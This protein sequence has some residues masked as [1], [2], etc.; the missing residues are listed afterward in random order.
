[1][2]NVLLYKQNFSILNSYT[3]KEVPFLYKGD[4]NPNYIRVSEE[5][6]PLSAENKSLTVSELDALP[7]FNRVPVSGGKDDWEH[8]LTRSDFTGNHLQASGMALSEILSSRKDDFPSDVDWSN[9]SMTK[10]GDDMTVSGYNDGE[11]VSGTSRDILYPWKNEWSQISV[12]KDA[13]SLDLSVDLNSSVIRVL[14]GV[15]TIEPTERRWTSGKTVIPNYNYPYSTGA[16]DLEVSGNQS[17]N[18]IYKILNSESKGYERKWLLQSSRTAI[19]WNDQKKYWQLISYES[20]NKEK[21]E[22]IASGYPH[23]TQYISPFDTQWIYGTVHE[24]SKRIE[25]LNGGTNVCTAHGTDPFSNWSMGT[26]ED[27]D[28][29]GG[30]IKIYGTFF[31]ELSQNKTNHLGNWTN[32]VNVVAKGDNLDVS[33]FDNEDVN[34][35]Y[36]LF[37][38]S[39]SSRIWLKKGR[40]SK[41]SIS[42]NSIGLY[43]QLCTTVDGLYEMSDRSASG[44]FRVWKDAIAIDNVTYFTNIICFSR[45]ENAWHIKNCKRLDLTFK[46]SQQSEEGSDILWTSGEYH[47]E[48]SPEDYCWKLYDVAGNI[49]SCQNITPDSWDDFDQ[50]TDY[51]NTVVD[52][53]NYKVIMNNAQFSGDYSLESFDSSIHPFSMSKDASI[54]TYYVTYDIRASRWK[55]VIRLNIDG[56]YK[57][58]QASAP[59]KLRKWEKLSSSLMVENSYKIVYNQ[60]NSRWEIIDY[61]TED[62]SYDHAG[63][64]RMFSMPF[65]GDWEN[66]KVIEGDGDSIEISDFSGWEDASGTYSQH[67]QQE[68]IYSLTKDEVFQ[69]SKNYFIKVG[70]SYEIAIVVPGDQIEP[71]SYYEAPEE[72]QKI[73]RRTGSNG[74]YRILW[75]ND[76]K[77]WVL[78]FVNTKVNTTYEYSRGSTRNLDKWTKSIGPL[79]YTISWDQQNKQ[80]V[81][82]NGQNVISHSSSTTLE[83]IDSGWP[84]QVNISKSDQNLLVSGLE[85]REANGTYLPD[86]QQ[87]AISDFER[88]W[89]KTSTDGTSLFKIRFNLNNLK[90]EINHDDLDINGSYDPYPEGNNDVGHNRRWS[91]KGLKYDQ[92]GNLI[93]YLI[94][95]N[96]SSS[97]WEIRRLNE[98]FSTLDQSA[99]SSKEY[100]VYVSEAQAYAKIE[101]GVNYSS[102]DEYAT[103]NVTVGG[104]TYDIGTVYIR[105]SSVSGHE[106][107]RWFERHSVLAYQTTP[108]DEPTGGVWSSG[109]ITDP[110]ASSSVWS[111][112]IK[113]TQPENQQYNLTVSGNNNSEGTKIRYN[114]SYLIQDRTAKGSNRLWKSANNLYVKWVESNNAW[115]ITSNRSLD[116]LNDAYS[117]Y[118]DVVCAWTNSSSSYANVQDLSTLSWNTN[119][120][121]FSGNFKIASEPE[122]ET[123]SNRQFWAIA[124]YSYQDG[125]TLRY[126]TSNRVSL[127]LSIVNDDIS[128]VSLNLI[129]SSGDQNYTGFYISKESDSIVRNNYIPTDLI[130]VNYSAYSLNNIRIKFSGVTVPGVDWDHDHTVPSIISRTGILDQTRLGDDDTVFEITM[131]VKDEAGNSRTLSKKIT[132]ISRLWR[133]KGTNIKED[134]S[135]YSTNVYSISP[136]GGLT[137][138]PKTK[139]DDSEYGYVRAWDDIFYPA[140]HGYPKL[141]D[142]KIDEINAIRISQETIDESGKTGPTSA[143]LKIYDRLNLSTDKTSLSTDQDGRY[144]TSGWN[145]SKKYNRMESSSYG[146]SGENLKYWIIDNSGYS[147]LQLEFEYFDLSSQVSNIPR[148]NLSPYEGDV[149][150]IYDASAE[151]CLGS[152]TDI[153]GK[154]H[155]VLADSSKLVEIYAFTGSHYNDDIAM[156]SDGSYTFDLQDFGFI[157]PKITST[158]KICLILYTDNDHE[159]SGF[160]I[161]SGPKHAATLY[162]YELKNDTGEIWIHISPESKDG[163]Y[164][165]PSRV[166]TTHQYTTANALI[167]HERSRVIF[168]SNE[169][170]TITGDLTAYS[171][172]KSIHDIGRTSLDPSGEWI[173]SNETPKSNFRHLTTGITD[174]AYSDIKTFLLYNDDCVDYYDISLCVAPSGKSTNYSDIYDYL[175]PSRNFGKIV[176]G[177]TTNKDKGVISFTSSVPLGR[178]FASYNYHTYYRL[179]NDGYGDLYFY[180]NALIPSSDYS[181]TGLKDWTYV[182]LMIYNEGSN[183]LSEGLMKFMSRGYISGSGSTQT[184]TQVVDENRPW[185][186]QSGTV[187]ETVNQTGASF[188]SSYA[189][190]PAKTRSA[191]MNAISRSS[192]GVSLGSVLGARSKAYMRIYWCLAQSE[193]GSSVTYITTTRG[194]KLWSSEISGKY[195]VVTM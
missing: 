175:N 29:D 116:S 33:G 6:I 94:N 49:I 100:Y 57:L 125:S 45:Y 147:D 123:G 130:T 40:S 12:M 58:D 17:Y 90:W 120:Y 13:D 98:Y 192:G 187:A 117:R 146:V 142:G 89:S 138:I 68:T 30:R 107:D 64:S 104:Q 93:I 169:G 131:Q 168:D 36:E 114:S 70:D 134:Q 166:S 185:D 102:G 23:F 34:G 143:E 151:G 77:N 178:M 164:S 153:Y 14:E 167:D 28:G 62:Y 37:N 154:S 15:I 42:Y 3:S 35:E 52:W 26:A 85:M 16:Y 103:G 133:M 65:E 2:S 190:L 150:V 56:K 124:I 1:M 18:G 115:A 126:I 69:L 95:H 11:Y 152:E 47:M 183:S 163:N 106:N 99:S 82:M 91:H 79:L 84:S 51:E 161:K 182:D 160:K 88:T 10:S 55:L 25:F 180:D 144:I 162:N 63:T 71:N 118:D 193:N 129:G 96:S 170:S 105:S 75:N 66:G 53:V 119:Y 110:F 135:G 72:I 60:A 112:G 179:T 101:L 43:W 188:N 48:Y 74:D 4:K 22:V 78:E 156:K 127:R 148:N 5:E 141:E 137:I 174:Y 27:I 9:L 158:S 177:T 140:S 165:S 7:G 145:R 50:T 184:I 176:S 159:L 186:V 139:I 149:L 97:R 61:T 41:Y 157:T 111:V 171:Y 67:N 122:K 38:S 194:R 191:A 54:K 87:G 21:N 46:P 128:N 73:W 19:C 80:W 86:A 195:Y 113:Y 59:L 136:T 155:P 31:R 24:S 39:D 92:E 76:N 32:N 81:L 121:T 173:I 8:E 83:E 181:L 132:H 44:A 172:L 109:E 189:G 20:F 108:D